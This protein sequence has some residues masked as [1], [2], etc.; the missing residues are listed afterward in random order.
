MS[1]EEKEEGLG[2]W[3]FVHG[4]GAGCA[5]IFAWEGM[6]H[7]LASGSIMIAIY[8]GFT[9]IIMHV[10]HRHRVHLKKQVQVRGKTALPGE[11]ALPP[12][13]GMDGG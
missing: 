13:D 9:V 10:V 1:E 7:V 12:G 8:G 2:I 6:R 4:T 5:S 11:T 3:N